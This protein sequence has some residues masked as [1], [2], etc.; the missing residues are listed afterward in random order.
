MSHR[1][2]CPTCKTLLGIV[3]GTQ[4]KIRYKTAFYVVD[5][6]QSVQTICRRCGAKVTAP[7]TSK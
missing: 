7:P 4:I 1:W 3:D 6:P 5:R 2:N